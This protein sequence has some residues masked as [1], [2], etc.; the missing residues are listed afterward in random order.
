M[1]LDLMLPELDGLEVCKRLKQETDTRAIKIILL[2][3][4]TDEAAKI[5][6]LEHGT[7]DFLTKPFSKIEIQTRLHNLLQTATLEKDL[8]LRNHDLEISLSELKQTQ[9]QLIQSEKLNALGKLSAGLLHEINNPLNFTLLALQTAKLD[10]IVKNNNELEETFADIDEGMQRIQVIVNDLHTFAHPSNITNQQHFV[11]NDTVQSA[12]RFTEHEHQDITIKQELIDNTE[13][14]GSQS[15]IMQV[16]I[17]L[18]CN[19]FNAI[20]INNRN[21]NGEVVISSNCRKH[22]LFVRLRDNGTGIKP[23]VISHVF[24]PF[25]TTKDVGEGM[26]LGLS[27]CH[28]IIENHGGTLEAKSEYGQWTEF[29]FD[30][31]LAS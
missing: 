29:N 5:T 18:F 14:I 7:D 27:I 28:A 6:A 2:T 15:H 31:P 4:R 1:I 11:F 17:N 23:D 13:V 20:K 26:G 10:P 21:R 9:S 19:S 22:R 16:L 24:D 30:L 12:L 25:Y 8:H 3:A